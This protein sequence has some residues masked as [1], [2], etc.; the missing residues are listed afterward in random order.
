MQFFDAPGVVLSS[1]IGKLTALQRLDLF[2]IEFQVLATELGRL[3]ALEYLRLSY[4]NV[5][6]HQA[7]HHITEIYLLTRLQELELT[8][9]VVSMSPALARLSRLTSL[10]LGSSMRGTVTS[11]IFQLPALRQLYGN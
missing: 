10:N 9:A 2:L 4:D 5:D 3:T 1:A 6:L 7:A 8:A 11:A